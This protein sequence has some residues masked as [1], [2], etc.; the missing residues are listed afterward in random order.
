MGELVCLLLSSLAQRPPQRIV[1]AALHTP[2]S[3]ML[4]M[5]THMLILTSGGQLAYH[6]PKDEVKSCLKMYSFLLS[7]GSL[8]HTCDACC[9]CHMQLLPFLEGLGHICPSYFNPADFVLELVSYKKVAQVKNVLGS[10]R[11]QVLEDNSA[12]IPIVEA[13]RRRVEQ[14]V[15]V[16]PPDER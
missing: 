6:G 7:Y 3:R 2:S 4:E 14:Y 11:D 15:S 1:V 16:I 13:C 12:F 10:D 5:F 8:T 9:P